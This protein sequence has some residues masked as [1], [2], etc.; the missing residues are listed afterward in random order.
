VIPSDLGAA[1]VP[2]VVAPVAVEPPSASR[3][4]KSTGTHGL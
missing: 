3:P 2:E 4:S 1:L